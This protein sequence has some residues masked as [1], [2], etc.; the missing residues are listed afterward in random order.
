MRLSG[1]NQHFVFRKIHCFSNYFK[2]TETCLQNVLETHTEYLWKQT[3]N[4]GG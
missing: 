2:V 3:N 1:Y 4:T